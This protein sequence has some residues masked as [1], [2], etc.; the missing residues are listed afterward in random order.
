MYV[1]RRD[2]DGLAKVEGLIQ[3]SGNSNNLFAIMNLF[4]VR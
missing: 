3:L 1:K 2:T 4:G